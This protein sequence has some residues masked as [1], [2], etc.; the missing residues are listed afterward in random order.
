MLYISVL[1]VSEEEFL[2]RS[3]VFFSWFIQ[4]KYLLLIFDVASDKMLKPAMIAY[5]KSFSKLLVIG[6]ATDGRIVWD[7]SHVVR[8]KPHDTQV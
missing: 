8:G 6:G 3:T 5:P 1:K 4:R 2:Y 7:S